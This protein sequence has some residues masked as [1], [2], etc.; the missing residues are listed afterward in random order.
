M[1]QLS[2]AS[3]SYNQSHNKISWDEPDTLDITGIEPDIFGYT[4]CTVVNLITLVKKVCS[5]VTST[6]I[7]IPKYPTSVLIS[8]FENNIVGKSNTATYHV[9]PCQ[10]TTVGESLCSV[11]YCS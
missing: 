5:N 10:Q 6:F 1:N 2:I 4:V 9:D 11:M 3:I 8:I 7:V